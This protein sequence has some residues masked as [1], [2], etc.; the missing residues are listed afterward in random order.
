VTIKNDCYVCLPASGY[1]SRLK[2]KRLAYFS[3]SVWKQLQLEMSSSFP[4]PYTSHAAWGGNLGQPRPSDSSFNNPSFMSNTIAQPYNSRDS[5][6][7]AAWSQY[8]GPGQKSTGYQAPQEHFV[9]SEAFTGTKAADLN[10]VI[11]NELTNDDSFWTTEVFPYEQIPEGVMNVTFEIWEFENSL[12]SQM[13]EESVARLLRSHKRAGTYR[14]DRYGIG[15]QMEDGFLGTPVG[16]YHFSMQIQQIKNAIVESQNMAVCWALLDANPAPWQP[17]NTVDQRFNI[18]STRQYEDML[19]DEVDMFAFLHKGNDALPNLITHMKNKLS[20]Q[21]I[22]GSDYTILPAG[23]KKF[24][25]MTPENSKYLLSGKPHTYSTSPDL[26]SGLGIIRES[27]VFNVGE[28]DREVGMI[29]DPFFK[30]CSIGTFAVMNNETLQNMPAHEYKTIFRT[31]QIYDGDKD[32]LV[33]ITLEQAIANCGLFEGWPQSADMGSHKAEKTNQF[34]LDIPLTDLGVRYFSVYGSYGDLINR[35]GMLDSCVNGIFEKLGGDKNDMNNTLKN[36]NKN[37]RRMRRAQARRHQED[38]SDSSSD[39]DEDDDNDDKDKSTKKVKGSNSTF[40]KAFKT[41]ER[42]IRSHT[43]KDNKTNYNTWDEDTYGKIGETPGDSKNEPF[44]APISFREMVQPSSFLPSS[45]S[46]VYDSSSS[47]SS[48]S[49][50]ASSTYSS[51]SS[52]LSTPSSSSSSFSSLSAPSSSSSSFSSPVYDS[53]SSSSYSSSSSS[54][55]LSTPTNNNIAISEEEQAYIVMMTGITTTVVLTLSGVQG[56]YPK[57][58]DHYVSDVFRSTI[59]ENKLD[60]SS[61]KIRFSLYTCLALEMKD[62]IITR[63]CGVSKLSEFISFFQDLQNDK[64]LWVKLV[65]DMDKTHTVYDFVSDSNVLGLT[66]LSEQKGASAPSDASQFISTYNAMQTFRTD[67]KSTYIGD[68]EK[69]INLILEDVSKEIRNRTRDQLSKILR[70]HLKSSGKSSGSSGRVRIVCKTDPRYSTTVSHHVALKH[71]YRNDDPFWSLFKKNGGSIADKWSAHE[72]PDSVQDAYRDA[73]YSLHGWSVWEDT[74]SRMFWVAL[75]MGLYAGLDD[76]EYRN[77]KFSRAYSL[78]VRAT[79]TN[80]SCFESA[81]QFVKGLNT[82]WTTPDDVAENLG[83]LVFGNDSNFRTFNQLSPDQKAVEDAVVQQVQESAKRN[84]KKPKEVI[85]DF[86][87]ACPIDNGDLFYW[88]IKNDVTLPLGFLLIRHIC[89]FN[90]GS[91]VHLVPGPNTGKTLIKNPSWKIGRETNTGVVNA[92]LT[93]WFK[94]IA[95]KPQHITRA[96]F[97]YSKRYEG[98]YGSNFW[99]YTNE[100]FQAYKSEHNLFADIHCVAVPVDWVPNRRFIDITGFYNHNMVSDIDVNP[101]FPSARLYA[102]YWGWQH[103]KRTMDSDFTNYNQSTPPEQNTICVQ[104]TTVRYQY[105][106]GGQCT[107]DSKIMNQGHWAQEYQG[108]R[109]VRDGKSNCLLPVNVDDTAVFAVAN[110]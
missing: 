7:N 91:A 20:E 8:F 107:F 70:D 81:V 80:P 38:E 33:P 86:L 35:A 76:P 58:W 109:K 28:A 64:L 11:I 66:Q 31:I 46:P 78:F 94:A 71:K 34:G 63:C 13:P 75:L 53:S 9:Y 23:A 85:V 67:P 99:P 79:T 42:V 19:Q 36:I 101:H 4:G 72:V 21:G 40:G 110:A 97:V 108:C 89:R 61:V 92:N 25:S 41:A 90:M 96:P 93:I 47:S 106:G 49:S 62:K 17:A 2:R 56:Q 32:R 29:T 50:F 3:F 54:Q 95:L 27:R 105:R 26:G 5:S 57:L 98:G 14:I 39:E 37:L 73:E 82:E 6:N 74:A 84:A 45:S 18:M 44:N 22:T 51:L 43:K 100:A 69:G 48:S 10:L 88:M 83:P 60:A 68:I 1:Q 87:Y 12:L 59:S 30:V 24:V 65:A 77:T 104:G 55:L 103:E 52:S 16:R 15:L 102:A